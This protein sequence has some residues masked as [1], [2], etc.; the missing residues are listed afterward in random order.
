MNWNTTARVLLLSTL[1]LSPVTDVDALQSFVLQVAS[2]GTSG[3]IRVQQSND[4]VVWDNTMMFGLAGS[5]PII[6]QSA[7]GIAW[8]PIVGRYLKVIM[9]TATTA[10]TTAV[11]MR[12]CEDRQP[13]T[14]GTT[15]VTVQSMPATPA[16]TNLI[17]ASTCSMSATAAMGAQFSIHRLLASAATTNAT[18]V[19]TSVGRLAQIRGYNAGAAGRYLKLY[20][21]AS[22]PT[23][24]TDT[25]C[26]YVRVEV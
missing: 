24:G 8:G 11:R 20:N 26:A 5:T 4:G 10:G 25:P 14:S 22:A 18:S 7:V 13:D 15:T 12:L 1:C 17:G 19:K 23:V 9:N 16:G 21:K 2:I 6:S 3:V